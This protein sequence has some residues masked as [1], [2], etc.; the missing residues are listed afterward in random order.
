[1]FWPGGVSTQWHSRLTTHGSNHSQRAGGS[2]N[3]VDPRPY[4]SYGQASI[5]YL[6][7]NMYQ[8]KEKT[9]TYSLQ[10]MGTSNHDATADLLKLQPG[11]PPNG[12]RIYSLDV[13]THKMKQKL[14]VYDVTVSRDN[15]N[16]QTTIT[17]NSLQAPKQLNNVTTKAQTH[18]TYFP[19]NIRKKLL[20]EK[21][22]TQKGPKHKHET[23]TAPKRRGG[24][25]SHTINRDKKIS[26]QWIHNSINR[27]TDFCPNWFE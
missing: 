9:S 7:M 5:Y 14:G 23:C 2:S 21:N 13:T 22:I 10:T 4:R 12:S 20:M 1:M 11:T 16:S 17:L 6:Y 19:K 18:K 25:C 3:E 8:T 24:R 26:V 15:N 27:S